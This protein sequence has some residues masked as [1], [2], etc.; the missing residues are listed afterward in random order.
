MVLYLDVH[1]HID[2]EA[3]N[4][5][6]YEL[7]EKIKREGVFFINAGVDVES[8]ALSVELSKNENVYAAVGVH[9]HEAAKTNKG[10]IDELKRFSKNSK[11]VA[12]GEVGLDYHYNFS[13]KQKQLGVFKE[14]LYLAGEL[15]LPVVVHD[16]EAHEDVLKLLEEV[17]TQKVMLHCFSGDLYMAEEALKKG[18]YFS[19]GGSMTFK[20]N[21]GGRE[22]IKK[23]PVKRT[24]LETDSPYLTPEPFRGKR[25]DP[26]FIKIIYDYFAQLKETGLNEIKKLMRE[27]AAEFFGIYI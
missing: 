14:Q 1:A 22:I 9:P 11:V 7:I 15:N 8:S 10:F 25:N 18:Y 17:G 21:E 24:F 3:F 12:I 27:N 20:K 4:N 23:L 26:T 5:D 6:R 2:D 13:P 16:R 19:F